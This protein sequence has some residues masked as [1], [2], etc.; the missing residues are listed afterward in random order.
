MT[1]TNLHSHKGYFDHSD[2][3]VL[4]QWCNTVH[5][6]DALK[7][8]IYISHPVSACPGSAMWFSPERLC[9]DIH[10]L[11]AQVPGRRGLTWAASDGRYRQATKE[12]VH[13]GQEGLQKTDRAESWASVGGEVDFIGVRA[14]WLE[15]SLILIGRAVDGEIEAWTPILQHSTHGFICSYIFIAP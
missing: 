12:E 7:K 2:D 1:A 10:L 3:G 9:S 14:G 8:Y 11:H 15:E 13:G 5:C 4:Q 6:H